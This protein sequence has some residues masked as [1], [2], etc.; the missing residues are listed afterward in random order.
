M[1]KSAIEWLMTQLP[2]GFKMTIAE[3]LEEAKQ[4]EA[5]IQQDYYEQGYDRG[6]I[7]G[8]GEGYNEGMY[9]GENK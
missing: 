4:I 9:D 1:N 2:I 3:K 5:D 8:Y 7:E 6:R